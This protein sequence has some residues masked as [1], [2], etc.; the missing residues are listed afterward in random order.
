MVFIITV[1]K[2][3]ISNLL[4]TDFHLP[5]ILVSRSQTRGGT[6][7]LLKVIVSERNKKSS[8]DY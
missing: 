4:Y 7:S 1:F 5:L 8:D 3:C 2:N 6:N